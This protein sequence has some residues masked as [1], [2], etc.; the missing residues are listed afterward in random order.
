MDGVEGLEAFPGDVGVDLGGGDVGVA[1][2]QLHHPQVGPVVEQVGGEGVAQDVGRQPGRVDAGGQGM[3]LDQ[4]PEH[5]A[6]HGAAP[7]R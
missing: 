1:E 5:L 6:G 3:A 2:E 7:G 4:G